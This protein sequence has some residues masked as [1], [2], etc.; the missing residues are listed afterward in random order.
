MKTGAVCW[1]HLDSYWILPSWLCLLEPPVRLSGGL[2]LCAAQTAVRRAAIWVHGRCFR[3]VRSLL[4]PPGSSKVTVWEATD[5]AD[6]C[7]WAPPF[8][9]QWT[10][11]HW[12]ML[13]DASTRCWSMW[14][15]FE[16]LY[17]LPSSFPTTSIYNITS[18]YFDSSIWICKVTCSWN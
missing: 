13:I 5:E 6:W 2:I 15:W 1:V 3:C 12:S 10:L 18:L 8:S 9:E 7:L 4:R 11:Y 14:S 17:I 16:W